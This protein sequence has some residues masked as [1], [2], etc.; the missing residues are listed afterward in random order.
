MLRQA[1]RYSHLQRAGFSFDR[2][3]I[4]FHGLGHLEI[5]VFYYGRRFCTMSNA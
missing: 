1:G 2:D 5:E 3:D 4:R